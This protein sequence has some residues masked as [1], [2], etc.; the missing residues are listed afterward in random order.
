MAVGDRQLYGVR[1]SRAALER[2]ARIVCEVRGAQDPDAA[3][4]RVRIV[5]ST[6]ED[7]RYA[8]GR[9][10]MVRRDALVPARAAGI[11]A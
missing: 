4:V 3:Y 9:E 7:R 11:A 8:A 10:R 2:G 5:H 6:L 1:L